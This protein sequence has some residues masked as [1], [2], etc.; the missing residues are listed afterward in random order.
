MRRDVRHSYTESLLPVGGDATVAITLHID[1]LGGRHRFVGGSGHILQ[2]LF[3]KD[4]DTM[5]FF[6]INMHENAMQRL[7]EQQFNGSEG[8]Y[9]YLGKYNTL[10]HTW[11][12]V[13]GTYHQAISPHNFP[14]PPRPQLSFRCDRC[15]SIIFGVF[16]SKIFLIIPNLVPYWVQTDIRFNR[17]RSRKICSVKI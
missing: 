5:F 12:Y 11:Q 10:W 1:W 17:D 9:A 7:I 14:R 2:Y 6:E 15:T 3:R 13:L 16:N 4:R 8:G